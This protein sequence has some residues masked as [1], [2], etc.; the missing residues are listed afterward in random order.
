MFSLSKDIMTDM[1][2]NL[3]SK[4]SM[5]IKHDREFTEAILVKLEYE[6]FQVEDIIIH[7]GAKAD[8]M[9]FIEHGHVLVKN[10]SFQVELYDGDHFGGDVWET[11]CSMIQMRSMVHIAVLVLNRSIRCKVTVWCATK[12]WFCLKELTE[13][14]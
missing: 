9:F 6:L 1:C 13:Q 8:H 11:S 4:G 3:L 10:E 5:F 7:Q 2:P 12:G 14:Y